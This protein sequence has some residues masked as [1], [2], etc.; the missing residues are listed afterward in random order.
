MW[1]PSSGSSGSRLNRPDEDVEPGDE[2]EQVRSAR[3][4]RSREA[5]L[6]ADTG[7][8]DQ[9]R[10]GRRGRA[11]AAQAACHSRGS[12]PGGRS[13]SRRARPRGPCGRRRPPKSAGPGRRPADAEEADLRGLP[14]TSSPSPSVLTAVLVTRS[15]A[16]SRVPPSRTTVSVHGRP[17]W[18]ADRRLESVAPVGD[19]RAVEGDDPVAGRSPAALAGAA[20]S[21]WRAGSVAGRFGRR[22]THRADRPSRCGCRAHGERRGRA[23]SRGSG[24][25]RPANT[26]MTRFHGL[27]V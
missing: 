27:R 25:E 8:A 18:R 21:A 1:P 20:G 16:R 10:P 11:R 14:P 22:T 9:R 3:G 15:A 12:W 2:Q 19:R 7:R 4:R 17:G 5:T 13:R 26:T 23:R 6:A 24:H